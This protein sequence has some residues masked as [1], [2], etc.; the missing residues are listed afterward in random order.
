MNWPT[1]IVALVIAGILAAIVVTGI[2]NKK[3]GKRMNTEKNRLRE[4]NTENEENMCC[5]RSSP[6]PV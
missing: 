3:K 6:Y 4:E 5:Y 1:V 2:I